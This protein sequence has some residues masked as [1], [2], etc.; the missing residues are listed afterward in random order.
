[1]IKD[2]GVLSTMNGDISLQF[3]LWN[4]DIKQNKLFFSADISMN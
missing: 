1:M 2:F 3:I 4:E